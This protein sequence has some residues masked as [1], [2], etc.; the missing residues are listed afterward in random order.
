MEENKIKW[1]YI[2]PPFDEVKGK[3]VIVDN[4]KQLVVLL[5]CVCQADFDSWFGE[6]FVRFSLINLEEELLPLDGFMPEISSGTTYTVYSSGN[7]DIYLEVY[8]Q[9]QSLAID[10]WNKFVRRLEW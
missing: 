10:N 1:C 4:G 9:T 2:Q 3:S 7:K 6:Y 8:G 5:R